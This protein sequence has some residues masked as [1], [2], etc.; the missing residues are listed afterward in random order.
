MYVLSFCCVCA[1]NQLVYDA[2]LYIRGLSIFYGVSR[3]SRWTLFTVVT[4]R[5][6][7]QLYCYKRTYVF[8]N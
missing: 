4:T 7:N 6:N 8:E 3:L 1:T 5:R 2:R